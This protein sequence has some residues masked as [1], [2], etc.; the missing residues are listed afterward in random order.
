MKKR[1]LALGLMML[2]AASLSHADNQTGKFYAGTGAGLYYV[3]FDNLDYDEGAA[4][5]R[6]FGGYSLNQYVSFEAGYTKLFEVS[7]DVLGVD[8][9]VDGS[10]WDLSVRPTLPLGDNFRAFGIIGWS[11]YDFEVKASAPGFNVTSSDDGD[12]LHYGLG[13]AFDLTDSWTLRGEWITVDVS[14]ADF[15][16]ASLSASYNFR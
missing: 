14:D 2:G 9:D 12:E 16:M 11:S 8:V 4:T 15:G 6:G 10:V 5:L 13:A 7:D 3:D 1:T